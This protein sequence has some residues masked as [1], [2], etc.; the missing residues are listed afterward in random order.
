MWVVRVK[1]ICWDS[2]EV[3]LTSHRRQSIAAT[4][5][6]YKLLLQSAFAKSR[7]ASCSQ[8]S[9]FPFFSLRTNATELHRLTGISCHMIYCKSLEQIGGFII[10]PRR[11]F[12]HIQTT[13][14]AFFKEIFPQRKKEIC[15]CKRDWVRGLDPRAPTFISLRFV[16]DKPFKEFQLLSID[17]SGQFPKQLKWL[18]TEKIL[19]FFESLWVP[20]HSK[21]D[22]SIKPW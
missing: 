18:K 6:C 4:N 17:Q 13:T 20:S 3:N 2:F 21:T 14:V 12:V 22:S 1:H 15:V 16:Q 7:R 19:I 5:C 10:Q 9:P 11:D 8:I